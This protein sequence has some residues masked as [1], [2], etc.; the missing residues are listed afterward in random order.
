[1][2]Y[3]PF[4]FDDFGGGLNLRDKAD[5]LAPNESLNCRDVVFTDKGAV[6][7]RPGFEELTG[8]ALTNVAESLHPFY[9]TSGTAQLLAG[10]G[11]RLEA[12]ATDGT[13]TASA[14]GL[15]AS[16]SGFY[17]D[18]CRVGTAS[19]E[20]AYAGNGQQVLEKWTGSAWSS[21]SNTPKAGALCVT[22]SSNRLVATRFQGTTGGPTGG[23]STSNPSRVYFSDPGAPETWTASNYID[24][25]PG[26]GE[27]IQAAV[28][29]REYVF[30]FKETKFYVFTEESTDADGNP[31]FNYRKVDT[32]I[33]MCASRAIVTNEDGVYFANEGGVYLTTGEAPTKLSG[34]V[35]HI[36]LANNPQAFWQ[37][38]TLGGSTKS[39]MAMGIWQ[40]LLLLAWQDTSGA[41]RTLVYDTEN[42][43]WSLWVPNNA[44]KCFSTFRPD[45]SEVLVFGQLGSSSKK[46]Q[47]M[48][49]T[50][51]SDNGTAI[52]SFW[53]TG[54]YDLGISEVKRIRQAK[55]WGSGTATFQVVSDFLAA[56]SG[57][58]SLA[59]AGSGYNLNP[60]LFRVAKR[61]TVFSFSM[62]N[63]TLD[64][65]WA[66]YRIVPHLPA[67]R[68]PT[69]VKT[70]R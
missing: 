36:F 29:W 35:D 49:G 32:G 61:G 22:P 41:H 21:V 27:A 50:A 66:L 2:T 56:A 6:L 24:L 42:G 1:M 64:T 46:V 28:T 40:N 13:V 63:N 3:T 20:T 30:V 38:G 69:V 47:M 60:Q 14:T 34:V 25:D 19:A 45:S 48:D 31:I 15:T 65:E 12:I 9:T 23:A 62:F 52:A 67:P 58:T 59:F 57:G 18:F 44:M 7:Q 11:T 55:V 10:C 16:A 5:R 17:W 8:T 70:D 54:F 4:V 43:W 68:Q 53:R 39:D 26:D 37:Y 33:G 51:T